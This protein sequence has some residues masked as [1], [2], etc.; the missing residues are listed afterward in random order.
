MATRSIPTASAAA[1]DW[2]LHNAGR[3]ALYALFDEI[4]ARY[5]KMYK[6]RDLCTTS[7]EARVLRTQWVNDFGGQ[8]KVEA[9][10]DLSPAQLWA[11]VNEMRAY[12]ITGKGDTK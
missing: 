2:P 5:P 6:R 9:L 7:P 8:E 12:F 4:C 3:V 11:A 1:A 10:N